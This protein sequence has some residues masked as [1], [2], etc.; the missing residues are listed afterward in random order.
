M[1]SGTRLYKFPG[2]LVDDS[3]IEAD[4][5]VSDGSD[6]SDDSSEVSWSDASSFDSNKLIDGYKDFL[7]M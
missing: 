1:Q 6:R 2:E 4:S 5:E 7:A 3:D